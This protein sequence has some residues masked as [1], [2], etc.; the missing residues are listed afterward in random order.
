MSL[1]NKKRTYTVEG[2]NSDLRR[3]IA[4]LHRKFF[5]SIDTTKAVFK[6]FF[7]AFNKFALAKFLYPSLKFAFSLSSFYE[8][9][10]VLSSNTFLDR[11]NKIQYHIYSLI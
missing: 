9:F 5:R 6:I 4:H 2:V 1:K 11:I 10:R 3:Y 8:L 7:H